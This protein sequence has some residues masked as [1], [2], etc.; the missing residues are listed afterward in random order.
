VGGA[1]LPA[2]QAQ[3]TEFAQYRATVNASGIFENLPGLNHYTI[4]DEMAS[5]QGRILHSIKGHLS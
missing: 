1:E 4:L 5:A 2:M 3:T